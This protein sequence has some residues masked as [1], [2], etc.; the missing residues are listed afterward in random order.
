MAGL[1]LD[2][3][4]LESDTR[5]A[6]GLDRSR[7]TSRPAFEARPPAIHRGTLHGTPATPFAGILH[8]SRLTRFTPYLAS[9]LKCGANGFEL[10]LCCT[11]APS[12]RVAAM[13]TPADATDAAEVCTVLVPAQAVARK[14][15][16]A[17]AVYQVLISKALLPSKLWDLQGLHGIMVMPHAPLHVAIC[18]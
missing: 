6:A 11:F 4:L 5:A 16:D 14:D 18:Q 2:W 8:V 3:L 10:R 12:S 7:S 9:R 15:F 13:T 17:D 1:H